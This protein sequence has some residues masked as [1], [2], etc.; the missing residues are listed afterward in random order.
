MTMKRALLLLLASSAGCTQL[1]SVPLPP[2]VRFL[3]PVVQD[4]ARAVAQLSVMAVSPDSQPV[5]GVR[6]RVTAPV[7]MLMTSTPCCAAEEVSLT[8]GPDGKATVFVR[9]PVDRRTF[10]LSAAASDGRPTGTADVIVAAGAPF[11]VAPSDSAARTMA[12][13]DTVLAPTVTVYDRNGWVVGGATITANDTSVAAVANGR[14]VGR[15]FGHT[16]LRVSAGNAADSTVAVVVMP[17]GT[18]YMGLPGGIKRVS[19][20]GV[21]LD[22]GSW[23]QGFHM[24]ASPS[25]D[26]Y[27]QTILVGGWCWYGAMEAIS[28]G[29]VQVSEAGRVA[30]WATFGADDS[31]LFYSQF[32]PGVWPSC[33]EEPEAI[34][35]LDLVSGT[36]TLISTGPGTQAS[37]FAPVVSPDG[38]TLL[39][40]ADSGGNS[41]IRRRSLSTGAVEILAVDGYGPSWAPDGSTFAYVRPSSG[42]LV[43]ANASGAIVSEPPLGL[44]LS[45]GARVAWSPDGAYLLACADTWGGL[46]PV[47]LRASDGAHELL[48]WGSCDFDWAKR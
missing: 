9:L 42:T 12:I 38:G 14:V 39:Y 27:V 8:T 34:Y 20:T 4:S 43:I 31:T 22:Q 7:A 1:E 33:Y 46:M 29:G 44:S 48:P 47:I 30:D 5:A 36:R 18:L 23:P 10:T 35:R 16:R 25:A 17:R 13:G 21:V 24:R 2:T 26:R 11:R 41:Y 6:V 3:T 15:G 28:I 40:Q 32:A 19:T 45:Y 37:E